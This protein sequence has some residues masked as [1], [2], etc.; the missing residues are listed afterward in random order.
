M[1]II[2]ESLLNKS[3]E[4]W[5]PQRT[6]DGQGGWPTLY[7][8]AGT[9]QG[10]MRPRSGSESVVADREE[11]QITHVLYVVAG[12]AVGAQIAR[13]WLIILGSLTVEVQGVREPSQADEH[14]EIDCRERQIETSQMMGES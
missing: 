4:V 11:R 14:L 5:Q 13:G 10:R 1:S 6:D 8:Q 7:V 9:V 12:D 2:F 3:Y